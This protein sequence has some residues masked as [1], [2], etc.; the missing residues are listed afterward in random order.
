MYDMME[1][2]TSMKNTKTLLKKIM[3]IFLSLMTMVFS[4]SVALA[5]DP[6]AL[7]EANI[8]VYPTA[9][10]EMFFGQKV[11]DCITISGGEVQYN[12]V[13]VPGTFK[14]ANPDYYPD[15]A[16]EAEYASITFVPADEGAYTGFTVNRSRNVT[17]KVNKTTLVFVD[18]S[19]PP[20]ATAVEPGAKLSTSVISG[21][22]CK[23]IYKE[24]EPKALKAT[25]RWKN[26]TS[27]IVSESGYYD[28]YLSAGSG[29]YKFELKIYV[30]LIGD[31]SETTIEEKPVIAEFEYDP[32][33]TWKDVP[34]TGGKAVSKATGA[35]V[36]GT[37][38]VTDT[39]KDRVPINS[40]TEI[41]VKFTPADENE[42]LPNEF[43]IPVTVKN[44]KPK[45]VN[46]KGEEIVPLLTVTY[47]TKVDDDIAKKLVPYV[48]V[49]QATVDFY[50]ADLVSTM[51]WFNTVPDIGTHE[52]KVRVK[53]GTNYDIVNLDFK[54][55]VLPSE[56]S[57]VI[58]GNKVMRITCINALGYA[59]EGTFD[60]YVNGE[61]LKS[62]KYEENFEWVP[63]KSGTYEMKAVYNQVENDR[64]II[65]DIVKSFSN[66][67]LSWNLSATGNADKT[68]IYGERA[69]V[70]APLLDPSKPDKPYYA[71]ENWNIVQ[72]NPQIS[73]EDMKQAQVSFDMPDEDVKLE[74]VYKFSFEFFFKYLFET[75]RAFFQ[76][77]WSAISLFFNSIISKI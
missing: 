15:S 25:W 20:V 26:G 28:A 24:D 18:E 9:S 77:M 60:I 75:I 39:W 51:P 54:V 30:G 48:N 72:G 23:N 64:Y 10:G 11:G 56:I 52:L 49:K 27:T 4:V 66:V 37:F 67:M 46:E 29:Y 35:E 6:I 2:I 16:Y 63:K 69:T 41:D 59:P 14:F 61:K 50:N 71:F 34:I 8:T 40:I 47:G 3:S 5:A 53:C 31:I 38:A 36:K 65:K 58:T 70:T 1:G 7:T 62:V 17:F 55:T 19:K 42:A 12:G 22:Q 57:P 45:F 74:A 44:A 76:N 43:K 13:V 21:G 32:A 33:L 73:E 68:Y